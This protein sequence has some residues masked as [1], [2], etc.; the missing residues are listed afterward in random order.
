MYN[1]GR[2]LNFEVVGQDLDCRPTGPKVF[3]AHTD[4]IDVLRRSDAGAGRGG[5][6]IP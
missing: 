4:S 2:N 3:A 6:L 1:L 5:F